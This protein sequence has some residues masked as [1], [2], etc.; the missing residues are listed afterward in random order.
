[1]AKWRQ[2]KNSTHADLKPLNLSICQSCNDLQ[3]RLES[4]ESERDELKQALQFAKSHVVQVERQLE[5]AVE[6]LR[7]ILSHPEYDFAG[8]GTQLTRFKTFAFSFIED[9]EKETTK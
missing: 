8:G 9:Y 5:K 1:M 3:Q 7:K 2:I 6:T 4:V